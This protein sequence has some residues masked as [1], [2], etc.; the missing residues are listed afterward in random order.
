MA[1]PIG[2]KGFYYNRKNHAIPCEGKVIYGDKIIEA[3]ETVT[4]F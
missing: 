2:E 3:D 4:R 1:T